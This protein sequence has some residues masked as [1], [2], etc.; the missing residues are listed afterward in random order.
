MPL[1]QKMKRSHSGV[2]TF[3]VVDLNGGGTLV[4]DTGIRLVPKNGAYDF[5][6][7]QC[8]CIVKID[9][10]VGAP[11]VPDPELTAVNGFLRVT[12]LNTAAPGNQAGGQLMAEYLHSSRR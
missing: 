5:A 8:R 12:L 3:L 4:V 10:K 11:V 6:L 7:D 9:S 2:W 1:V